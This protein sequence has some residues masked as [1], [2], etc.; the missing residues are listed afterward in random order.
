MTRMRSSSYS[1]R[2]AS[3]FRFSGIRNSSVPRPNARN[4]L[5]SAINRRIHHRSEFGLFDW[6]STFTASGWY[7]GSDTIGR[8]RRCGLARENPA[9]RS[10][11]HCMGVRTPLRSPR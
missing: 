4:L 6:V 2:N 3:T 8:Y 1:R 5:R 9:L 10:A 11:D 7:S